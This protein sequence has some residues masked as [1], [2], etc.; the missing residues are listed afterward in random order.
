MYFKDRIGL[1]QG[2]LLINPDFSKRGLK[3]P[4]GNLKGLTAKTR[5]NYAG[6]N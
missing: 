6:T 2:S 3:S 1:T 5:G 4:P